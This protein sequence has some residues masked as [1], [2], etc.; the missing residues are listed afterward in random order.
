SASHCASL[1]SLLRPGRLRTTVAFAS[2]RVRW[3]S[4]MCH[5]GF[6]YTPVDSSTAWVEPAATS[7]SRNARS[8]AAVVEN[9]RT[10]RC[11]RPAVVSRTHATTVC[12]CTSSP[13]QR[14]WMVSIVATSGSAGVTSLW[15]AVYQTC[16]R[17]SGGAAATITGAHGTS[18]PHLL[19]G[20]AHHTLIDLGAGL[21][22]VPVSPIADRPWGGAHLLRS[23]GHFRRHFGDGRF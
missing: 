12:L 17:P 13:A 6:Q 20:C 1:T 19:S 23:G 4:S 14:A 16:S 22:A 3:S 5:T 7:H 15:V 8:P 9:V 21:R 10:S 18:G 11:A 2:T